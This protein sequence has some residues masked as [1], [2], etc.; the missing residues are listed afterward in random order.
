MWTSTEFKTYKKKFDFSSSEQGKPIYTALKVGEVE[1]INMIEGIDGEI[2]E[3]Q[4][5]QSIICDHCGYHHCASGNWMAI[6]NY[7]DYVFF[8]PAFGNIAAEPNSGE[9]EPP[10]YLKREGAFWLT[11]SEFNRMV[12]L[13]PEF[14]KLEV[15]NRLS[16]L[17]LVSLYKWESP[18][19]MFGDFPNFS[20]LRTN[21]I[22]TVS[23]LDN[24]KISQIIQTKLEELINADDYHLEP[25]IHEEIVYVYLDESKTT[26]WKALC[27][28]EQKY[29]LVLGGKFKVLI[30]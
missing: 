4:I 22:L 16:K 23:E 26:E 2:D 1:F 19:K 7:K 8:I 28:S 10:Y 25:L 30:N 11:M 5:F 9:Y 29:E 15:I 12:E 27:K 20:P 21:H 18:H 14:K 6:R 24:N 3:E 13:I 17:E